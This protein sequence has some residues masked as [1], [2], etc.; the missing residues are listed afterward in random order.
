MLAY[1]ASK[2]NF[3]KCWRQ[4][5]AIIIVRNASEQCQQ[6]Q[7]SEML[8]TNVSNYKF[9]K[10]WRQFLTHI[11][12]RNVG[13]TCQPIYFLEMV[14]T[15]VRIISSPHKKYI[16]N[17]T[18]QKSIIKVS[19][20]KKYNYISPPHTQTI[21]IISPRNHC[22]SHRASHDEIEYASEFVFKG[23]NNGSNCFANQNFPNAGKRYFRHA[24]NH[25]FRNAGNYNC[26]KYLPLLVTEIS[27]ITIFRNIGNHTFLKYGQLQ[28]LRCQQL[29]FQKSWR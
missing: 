15:T 6:L 29:Y 13:D 11:L 24:G 1:N 19:P 26:P 2:F 28:F 23:C 27:A 20:H 9:P 10:C 4:I 7:L 22:N 16:Y 12:Y 17:F 25:S 3:H 8:A 21:L 14:A 18:P 5:S